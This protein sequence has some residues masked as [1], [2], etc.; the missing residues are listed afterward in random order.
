MPPE[1][2]RKLH[3]DLTSI[4]ANSGLIGW[5]LAIDLKGCRLAFPE[6]AS[7]HTA[8]SCFFRTVLFH[9]D[10]AR[11]DFPS[12]PLR[13]VFDRNSK[14]E[15]NSRLLVDYLAE[16]SEPRNE[17]W[18]PGGLEFVSREEVGVQAADLWVR[19]LMKY[20][21]GWLFSGDHYKP[22]EQ[23][24][25]LCGTGRF[26][27]DLQFGEYFQSMKDQMATLE[28]NTG[29]SQERYIA[30]L[31]QKKRQDNQSNRIEYVRYVAAKERTS[32]EKQTG[33]SGG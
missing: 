8:S 22:R 23:W 7:D 29:M 15:Y 12:Q 28:S 5:G 20:L 1:A 6:I 24:N 13:I 4:L 21:D 27:A 11:A 26:G 14:T 10:R 33:R 31:H 17:Q 2:R 16:E 32:A 3:I 9:I 30:W 19:E 18:L 25:V